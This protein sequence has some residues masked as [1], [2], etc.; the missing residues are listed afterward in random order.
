[1]YVVC[2]FAES[3]DNKVH[4]VEDGRGSGGGSVEVGAAWGRGRVLRARVF[5]RAVLG[6]CGS[7]SCWSADRD[8]VGGVRTDEGRPMRARRV[9]L[10]RLRRRRAGDRRLAVLRSQTMS[11]PPVDAAQRQRQ[12]VSHRTRLLPRGQLRLRHRFVFDLTASSFLKVT[13]RLFRCA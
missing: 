6:D 9:R 12:V 3:I 7:W 5:R 2:R 1:M 10:D 8:T 13:D 11:L 4:I